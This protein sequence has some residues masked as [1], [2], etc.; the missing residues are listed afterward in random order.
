MSAEGQADADGEPTGVPLAYAVTVEGS[1]GVV[2]GEN[3]ILH[4]TQYIYSSSDGTWTSR[5]AQRPVPGC[6]YRGLNAFEE[7]DSDLFFGR[8]DA[9]EQVTA[10]LSARA[11]PGRQH[12]HG[13]LVVSGPSGAGKSS[14]LR[15]GMLL[16]LRRDGLADVPGAESWPCLLFTPGGAPLSELA[17]Q[18]A[19]LAGISADEARQALWADPASFR[20]LARQAVL[21][22]S[23]R[24]PHVRIR[25]R[26]YP[27]RAMGTVRSRH[28]VP[29]AMSMKPVATEHIIHPHERAD[30][31]HTAPRPTPRTWSGA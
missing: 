6:P 8:D 17:A 20:V 13:I 28:S 23:G 18:V 7:Q 30:H 26:P 15:A 5:V 14:L 29:A 22:Q 25:R 11:R 31:P 12:A 21:A 27:P 2:V 1:S 10:R 3:N 24:G 9:I 16:R 19:D 4:F